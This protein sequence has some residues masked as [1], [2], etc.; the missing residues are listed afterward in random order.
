MRPVDAPADSSKAGADRDLLGAVLEV[1]VAVVQASVSEP[2]DLVFPTQAFPPDVEGQAIVGLGGFGCVQIVQ[3]ESWTLFN[4]VHYCLIRHPARHCLLSLNSCC[5]NNFPRTRPL[6][7]HFRPSQFVFSQ[8]LYPRGEHFCKGRNCFIRDSDKDVKH[9][10]RI[11]RHRVQFFGF[12]K[13]R[14]IGWSNFCCRWN[15]EYI[16]DSLDAQHL[17]DLLRVHGD[18]VCVIWDIADKTTH[19]YC[20]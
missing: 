17:L 8:L 9:N 6:D 16:L 19:G 13:D 11:F 1:T 5:H 15:K 7:I 18:D 4:P 12:A 20:T 2:D 14:K 10:F 3:D